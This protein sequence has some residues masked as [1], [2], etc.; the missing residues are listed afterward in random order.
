MEPGIE[1]VS[2]AAAGAVA[3]LPKGSE[4]WAEVSIVNA[5]GEAAYP[6]S[7]F[8]YLLVYRE[9]SVIPGMTEAKARALTEFLWWAVHEGQR[10]APELHYAPLPEEVVKLNE[11]TIKSMTYNNRRLLQVKA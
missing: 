4:S 10:Y 5:P 1:S 8:T 3:T 11:E 7:S 2:A 6:I 9:L